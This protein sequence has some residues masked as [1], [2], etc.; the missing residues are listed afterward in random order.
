MKKRIP[1]MMAILLGG[2]TQGA[3]AVV[4][5]TTSQITNEKV[6][7]TLLDAV[8]KELPE[9]RAVNA[10]YLNT[11]YDAYLNVSQEA[12]VS[13]TFLDEGAGY[14]NSLGYFTFND[15]SFAGLNKGD[16]DVD[17]N[18]V[19]SLNELDKVDG[20]DWQWV[21]PNASESGGGGSLRPGDTLTLNGGDTFQAG[22]NISFFLAQNTWT[23]SG[24]SSGAY[25]GTDQVM[26]GVDFLNPESDFTSTFDS[27]LVDSRHV[28]LMFADE[29][30]QQVIMGFEDLNRTNPFAN[31]YFYGSDNDFN[32]A[33]FLVRADPATA[34][35]SSDIATAPL[36]KVAGVPGLI[37]MA[38]MGWFAF[39]RGREGSQ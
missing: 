32:D 27:S 10:T 13:V 34:F 17:G 2:F 26:Y 18:G 7:P 8:V 16:I 4:A 6:D 38:G 36:P 25:T 19:V 11:D 22:E 23:G 21:F 20:V 24:V 28:A 39:R 31:D 14:R 3:W 1:W 33:V 37:L 30:Q 15:N 12:H 29:S 35:G 5:S 9:Q